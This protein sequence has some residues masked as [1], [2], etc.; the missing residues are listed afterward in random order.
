VTLG[1]QNFGRQ[2]AVVEENI[3]NGYDPSDVS[4]YNL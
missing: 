4:K 3:P 1:D 2:K